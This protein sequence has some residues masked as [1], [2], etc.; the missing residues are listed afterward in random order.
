MYSRDRLRVMILL[1]NVT[2]RIVRVSSTKDTDLGETKARWVLLNESRRNSSTA[3]QSPGCSSLLGARDSIVRA[4]S[5]EQ[6]GPGRSSQAR[7]KCR[8]CRARW[9]RAVDPVKRR[10]ST[11]VQIWLPPS[12]PAHLGDREPSLGAS[13]RAAG[14]LRVG[15]QRR[16]PLDGE[17]RA[18]RSVIGRLAI[19]IVTHTGEIK[20]ARRT[21]RCLVA[22]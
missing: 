10:W 5:P 3:C 6:C 11:V 18:K 2:A 15:R 22:I 16:L 14:A 19:G 21:T 9:P 20:P 8:Q 1:G 17:S 4:S 12:G 13:S 7:T